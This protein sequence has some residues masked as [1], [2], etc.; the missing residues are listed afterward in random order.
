MNMKPANYFLYVRKSSESEEKQV[1]SIEAQIV[2][3]EQDAKREG[4]KITE[5]FIESKSAKTPG[6][7]EFN[8]M[9]TKIYESKEP[10]GIIA[11][12]PDRL[13]RN[14]V[15]GG[16]IVYLID[17][18]KIAALRFPTFW[19][20]PT[21]Q[22]LFML[23]VAF[24]QS[25]YYSD[26]LSENVKRGIRQKIRRGEWIGKAPLGYINNPKTRNIEPDP[27]RSRIVQKL[28]EDFSK[29]KESVTSICQ[30]LF[31][32]GIT[33]G[34]GELMPKSS[35]YWFL[36]NPIYTGVIKYKDEIFEGT[37]EPII[38]SE[39]FEAVQSKLK[40]NSR[41]RKSKNKHD[42]VFTDLLKCGECGCSIT[43]QYGKGNGGTYGYYRCTKKRIKCSQGYVRENIVLEQMKEQLLK[44]SMPE[45]WSPVV[46]AQ[47]TKWENEER[48]EMQ[49]T[50]QKIEFSLSETQM[51]LDTLVNG[52]LDRIIERP[53]YLQKKE[54]LIKL[55]MS[56]E[57]KQKALAKKGN[58][59][60]EPMRE[61]LETCQSAGKVA[62]S[63]DLNEIKSFI[64]RVGTNR[65][66]KDK[67]VVL[68]FHQP[69]SLLLK[70]KRLSE[71]LLK[72]EK[73]EK[74]KG[75]VTVNATPPVWWCPLGSNQ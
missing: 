75:D 16:Q 35:V 44:I 26:N 27:V 10:V 69:F 32:F 68:E 31:D 9:I 50:A 70:Y 18:Q 40:Q 12:H 54:E 73:G 24:G 62:L 29:G 52:F 15:D 38:S 19:F 4:I 71:G 2:E 74:N 33:N 43:A 63:T 53:I 59:W 25:K 7:I 64:E 13:A 48:K 3:L 37:F 61:F 42:F 34:K 17:I 22:G 36:T 6:R 56:L 8:K 11:W 72:K 65:I 58:F 51:K 1:M 47:M 5:R 45:E 21:P 30:R 46:F 23:Q 57:L 66:I 49:I 67:N 41:P 28:F 55:K 39:I 14:S 60:L 20:E